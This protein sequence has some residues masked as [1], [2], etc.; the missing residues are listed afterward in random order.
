M[1]DTTGHLIRTFEHETS[2]Y[3]SYFSSDGESIFSTCGNNNIYHWKT[4]GELLRF[5]KF[6]D[7]P[8]IVINPNSQHIAG[9]ITKSENIFLWDTTGMIREFKGHSKPVSGVAFSPD[10]RYLLSWSA[11]HTVRLWDIAGNVLKTFVL[12]EYVASASF[13][14]NGKNILITVTDGKVIIWESPIEQVWS[15]WRMN[16][17]ELIRAGAPLDEESKKLIDNLLIKK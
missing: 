2:V 10:G 3:T 16:E 4:S 7:T 15:R 13:S 12:N 5:R 17:T 14:P 9:W 1:W 8:H 11:D 6:G